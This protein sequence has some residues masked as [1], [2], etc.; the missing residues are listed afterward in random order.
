MPRSIQF[1]E[2]FFIPRTDPKE[3]EAKLADLEDLESENSFENDLPNFSSEHESSQMMQ[4]NYN[5]PDETKDDFE[6]DEIP[7]S[8]NSIE[9][10]EEIEFGEEQA[11]A[12]DSDDSMFKISSNLNKETMLFED[13]LEIYTEV[14]LPKGWSSFVI[15]KGHGTTVVYSFTKINKNGIPVVE[16]QVFVKNNMILRCSV[17]SRNVD[18]MLHNLIRDN[19][20]FKIQSLL[21][22]EELIDEFNQ[23]QICDGTYQFFDFLI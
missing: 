7:N 12:L 14:S 9:E 22:V 19:R 13:L 2:S 3:V 4:T 6:E 10:N 16:K 18:P 5:L 15:P 17:R 8:Q 11:V 23:R 20:N 1:R 21:D